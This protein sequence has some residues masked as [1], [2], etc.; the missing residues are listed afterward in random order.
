MIIGLYCVT[1]TDIICLLIYD[2]LFKNKIFTVWPVIGFSTFFY[3]GNFDQ[4]IA[5]VRSLELG[6]ILT[7]ACKFVLCYPLVF[8]ICNGIRHLVSL[9]GVNEF[10][11]IN[12]SS[13]KIGL[14]NLVQ[15][16]WYGYV[17]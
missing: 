17:D 5:Y 9:F 10:Y 8:H 13:Y 15:K 14:N 4:V 16:V 6:K 7:T 1:F 11:L 12:F 2:C 3:A